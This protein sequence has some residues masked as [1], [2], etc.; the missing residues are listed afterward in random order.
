MRALALDERTEPA[1][2]DRL[3]TLKLSRGLSRQFPLLS[4]DHIGFRDIATVFRRQG[5]KSLQIHWL[6]Q[7]LGE[8]RVMATTFQQTIQFA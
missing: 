2:V 6:A 8:I 7:F 1:R 3:L 5:Q 4:S